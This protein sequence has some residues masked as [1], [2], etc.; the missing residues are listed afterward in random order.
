M[1]RRDHFGAGY[2]SGAGNPVS[3]TYTFIQDELNLKTEEVWKN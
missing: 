1:I 2:V 3:E